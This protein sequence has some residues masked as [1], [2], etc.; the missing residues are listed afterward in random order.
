MVAIDTEGA[1]FGFLEDLIESGAWKNIKQMSIE[2]H[3][4]P[5]YSQF[6][7]KHAR[8]LDKFRLLGLY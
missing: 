6:F 4:F 2:F 7:I 5:G 1:E 8:A 3:F